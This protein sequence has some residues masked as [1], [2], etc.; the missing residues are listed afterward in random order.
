MKGVETISAAHFIQF[1]LATG[2]FQLLTSL[3][4]GRELQTQ[5]E[6]PKDE[7]VPCSFVPARKPTCKRTVT[8]ISGSLFGL[9]GL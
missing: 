1:A 8:S 6:E 4:G 2:I 5:L 7:S 3:L 9:G